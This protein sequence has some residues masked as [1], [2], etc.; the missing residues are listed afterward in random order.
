MTLTIIA[1]IS[2]WYP[3][4]SFSKSRP[5]GIFVFVSAIIGISVCFLVTITAAFIMGVSGLWDD[6]ITPSE[7]VIGSLA[8]AV[9]LVI[10]SPIAAFVGWRRALNP[11]PDTPATPARGAFDN[12][13]GDGP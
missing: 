8:Q 2:A 12:L 1:F 5:R 13:R 11:K 6:M 7:W 9:W 10:V 3:A 4:Y